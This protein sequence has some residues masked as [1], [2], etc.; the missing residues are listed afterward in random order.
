MGWGG[1]V[2]E[3]EL[4]W[5]ISGGSLWS[6]INPKGWPYSFSIEIWKSIELNTRKL[7]GMPQSV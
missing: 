2:S 6:V 3:R 5:K 4:I 7:V 1:G